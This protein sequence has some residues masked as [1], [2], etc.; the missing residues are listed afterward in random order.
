M[1]TSELWEGLSPPYGTIVADPPWP[2]VWGGTAGGK[3]NR[4]TTLGYTTM[5]LEEIKALPVG[6]LV[7]DGYLLL[8]STRD[9]FREGEAAATAR[10]WGFEPFGE[11]IWHKAN[12]GMG[13]WPRT[14]HEPILLARKG[15][16]VAPTNLA[17]RSVHEWKQPQQTN[18]GK[19]HSAKPAGLADLAERD[20]PGPYVELFARAQRLGWDSWGHGYEQAGAA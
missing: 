19:T 12:F 18:G 13:R 8:W 17:V 9:L 10:A 11:M 15:K 4:S 1:G 2:F 20:L 5:P 3:R 14:C 16:P 7:T 6:D